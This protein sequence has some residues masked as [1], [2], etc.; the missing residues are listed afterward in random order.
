MS[1]ILCPEC[2]TK[3]SD[4]A[5]TC[6]NCG[7]ESADSYSP[8]SIQDQYVEVPDFKYEMLRWD[9]YKESV[10][11]ISYEDNKNLIEYLG[12]WKSIS[13]ILP[14]IASIIKSM[15]LK[16]EVYVAEMDSYVKSLIKK[17]IYK[18]SIDKDG[19]ILPTIRDSKKI[20]K[21]VRL[22]KM[23]QYPQLSSSLG[24]LSMNAIITQ[25][26]NEIEYI[27][28]AIEEISIGIQNDRLAKVDSSRDKLLQARRMK[29][30]RL[31]NFA[32]LN[33]INSATDAKHVLMKNFTHNLEYIKE[34]SQESFWDRTL[35]SNKVKELDKK[36]IEAFQALISITNVIQIE[37]EGYVMLGEYE[38]SKESL[39]QFKD[40]IIENNLD[41]RDTLLLINEN[42]N[43][44][45]SGVV[46]RFSGIVDWVNSF[47]E[48][49]Q[50]N[51]EQNINIEVGD[52]F[53]TKKTLE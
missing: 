42:L 14:D 10:I 44:K 18:F 35:K 49:G 33:I 48:T 11:N 29:D 27:G 9:S 28:E 19:R 36:S 32:I 34:N 50:I 26:L 41:Q 38:P 51:S 45:Q 3:I 2:G 47:N 16:E 17:G 6:P 20:I 1:L 22:K 40:F 15:A 31:R 24:H 7:Y 46:D 43:H 23:S 53:E 4:R 30:A 21:Q 12:N 8:I 52:N 25:I 39:I 5:T 13:T 37:C